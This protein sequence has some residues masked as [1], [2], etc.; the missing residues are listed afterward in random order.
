[1]KDVG[2]HLP[3]LGKTWRRG[4]GCAKK[5]KEK[6]TKEK[7]TTQ[8]VIC[9]TVWIASDSVIIKLF[10]QNKRYDFKLQ[11]IQLRTF[12]ISTQNFV[13][14]YWTDT[15]RHL[16][17]LGH[18]LSHPHFSPFYPMFVFRLVVCENVRILKQKSQEKNGVL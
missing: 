15:S 14:I 9:R 7:R 3:I 13:S 8:S 10:Q 16:C 4:S 2:T 18:M 12:L 1:M 17:L 5:G 6:R 11:L